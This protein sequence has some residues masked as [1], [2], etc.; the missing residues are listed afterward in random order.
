[1]WNT[2]LFPGPRLVIYSYLRFSGFA[3]PFDWVYACFMTVLLSLGPVLLNMGP[4]LL[5]L[6]P[7]IDLI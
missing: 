5:S 7:I 1:M 2:A 3:R 4:V 6:G